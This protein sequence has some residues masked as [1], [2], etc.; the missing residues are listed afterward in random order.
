[1]TVTWAVETAGLEATEVADSDEVRVVGETVLVTEAVEVDSAG[2]VVGVTLPVMGTGR[3]TLEQASGASTRCTRAASKS[4]SRDAIGPSQLVV[5]RNLTDP[6]NGF[7]K[8][9]PSVSQPKTA[10]GWM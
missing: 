5:M 1:V 6:E 2:G 3:S 7:L 9:K 4:I 10:S 8:S